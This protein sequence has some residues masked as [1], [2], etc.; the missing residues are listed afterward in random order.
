MLFIGIIVFIF[1]LIYFIWCE[2]KASV[3]PRA[4]FKDSEKVNLNDVRF[5]KFFP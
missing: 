2:I 1:I 3:F 4:G 5:V